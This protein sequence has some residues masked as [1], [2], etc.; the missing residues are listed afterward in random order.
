M[1]LPPLVLEIFLGSCVLLASSFISVVLPI[2][3]ALLELMSLYCAHCAVWLLY[4]NDEISDLFV[5]IYYF[6]F[7][8][9]LLLPLLI[10]ALVFCYASTYFVSH[11]LQN[12][13]FC[14]GSTSVLGLPLEWLIKAGHRHTE[15]VMMT[16]LEKEFIRLIILAI[17]DKRNLNADGSLYISV[18]RL[19]EFSSVLKDTMTRSNYS[20]SIAT[21]LTGKF[22]S[23]YRIPGRV[24][25][26]RKVLM[27]KKKRKRGCVCLQVKDPVQFLA[28]YATSEFA[29][30]IDVPR[31]HSNSAY[32]KS[33]S[34]KLKNLGHLMKV[35]L[36][37]LAGWIDTDIRRLKQEFFEKK[38]DAKKLEALRRTSAAYKLK[39]EQA[40]Q[41]LREKD[42]KIEELVR[43]NQRVHIVPVVNGS[44]NVTVESI[45]FLEAGVTAWVLFCAAG[46]HSVTLPLGWTYQK[47]SDYS[48]RIFSRFTEHASGVFSLDQG[49]SFGIIF[50]RY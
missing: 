26:S 15:K 37:G 50:F 48:F 21:Y 20:T 38:R 14:S 28:E 35:S 19:C 2:A 31:M 29:D 47:V 46:I 12:P 22:E 39:W 4:L 44:M 5:S 30:V 16:I 43:A 6:I 36:Q 11:Y 25:P 45:T 34:A 7:L 1:L 18:K 24:Q 13:W 32:R 33:V 8:L 17:K 49:W 42:I 23:V 40:E 41:A 10:E 3:E 9:S 27:S